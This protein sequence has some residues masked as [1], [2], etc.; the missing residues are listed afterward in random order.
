MDRIRGLCFDLFNTLVNVAAVPREVG[1]FTAD[2]L[3][4]Q[5]Q[6]WNHVCFGPGHEICR[7]APHLDTVR[8]LARSIDAGISDSSIQQ[9]TRER[10]QRF[11]HAL[12][13]VVASTV[14]LLARLRER[15]YKCAL[16]SNASS[17]EIHAWHRSPLADRFDT[18]VFSCDCGARKPHAFIYA[19]AL[20]RLELAANQCLFIGDGG[21]QEHRG[22][23]EAGL[24][25]VL[26]TQH[27]TAE[28]ITRIQDEQGTYL[29][30]QIATLDE[31]W[32]LLD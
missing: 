19:Q 27:L 9:A 24:Q 30:A 28:D 2:I 3:G 7:P 14:D 32:G 11:D 18:V 6:Q 4:V 21:S 22:A 8:R 5:R 23:W 20:S 15:G 10:Q 16:V 13:H 25:P 12:L 17:A 26:L 31:L 29:H 1:R